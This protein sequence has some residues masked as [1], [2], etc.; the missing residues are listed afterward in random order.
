MR[1][2]GDGKGRRRARQFVKKCHGGKCMVSNYLCYLPLSKIAHSI[3]IVCFLRNKFMYCILLEDHD[4]EMC[5]C[6][7]VICQQCTLYDKDSSV[8]LS[9]LM[10]GIAFW[11]ARRCTTPG[12]A[13]KTSA[14]AASWRGDRRMP[15]LRHKPEGRC[16]RRSFGR[17][18][19]LTGAWS[20]VML[21]SR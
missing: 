14:R 8:C 21:K 18:E 11:G 16:S 9:V 20:V 15:T 13:R 4:R 10:W 7:V 12:V 1:Y 19:R 6:L 2:G 3:A 17:N 5:S